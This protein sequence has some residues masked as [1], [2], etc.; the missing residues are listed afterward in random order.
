M[1]AKG[2]SGSVHQIL[3][4]WLKEQNISVTEFEL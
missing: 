3:S 4:P 1:K 2:I